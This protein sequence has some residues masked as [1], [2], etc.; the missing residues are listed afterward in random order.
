MASSTSWRALAAVSAARRGCTRWSAA[1][2]SARAGCATSVSTWR[3]STWTRGRVALVGDAGYCPALLS[4]M[5]TTLA[6]VGASELAVAR[7]ALERYEAAG[8]GDAVGPVE[9]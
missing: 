4:G 2:R 5:G 8:A 6:M 9:P 1:W 7:G 3:W